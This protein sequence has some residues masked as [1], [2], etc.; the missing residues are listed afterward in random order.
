[1]DRIREVGLQMQRGGVGWYPHAG[2]PFVHLDVGSV[3]MWPRMTHDQ[4]ARL[5]PDGKTVH[6][7]S[8]NRPFPRYEEAKAEILARGGTVA[9]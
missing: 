9:G 5:F 6:L 2:T 7:A 8:D 4:L 3:R 1:I